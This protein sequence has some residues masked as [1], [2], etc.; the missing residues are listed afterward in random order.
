[1]GPHPASV[2]LGDGSMLARVGRTHVSCNSSGDT[3]RWQ[4]STFGFI[5]PYITVVGSGNQRNAIHACGRVARGI[6]CLC[7]NYQ[8]CGGGRRR[9]QRACPSTLWGLNRH[10]TAISYLVAFLN[11]PRRSCGVQAP[12]SRICCRERV[13]SGRG[14]DL[15]GWVWV[16]KSPATRRMKMAWPA[17]LLHSFISCLYSMERVKG[18]LLAPAKVMS[19]ETDGRRWERHRTL[20][21]AA[22]FE[23]GEGRFPTAA[24]CR[25]RPGATR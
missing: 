25:C 13:A 17:D 21:S 3:R 18:L 4:A 24:D 19:R 23:E 5:R 20:V 22:S 1:M 11:S 2:E 6:T 12:P 14:S 9:W 10:G 8:T 16:A 15:L 7:P